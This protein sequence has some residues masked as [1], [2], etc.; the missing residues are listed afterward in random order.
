MTASR[1]D[2]SGLAADTY[3]LWFGDE[4][5]WDQRFFFETIAEERHEQ[6]AG[7]ARELQRRA[8]VLPDALEEE[9]L[10]PERLFAEPQVVRVGGETGIIPLGCGHANGRD[11]SA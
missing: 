3:D 7:P 5:F 8:A 9:T 1:W 2:Y 10:V 6:A 11:R 4:P